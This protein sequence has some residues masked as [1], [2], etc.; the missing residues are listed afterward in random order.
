MSLL[1]TIDIQGIRSIGVGPQN[2]IVIEFLTPLTII[3]G[4]NGSGK[5]VRSYVSLLCS[6]AYLHNRFVVARRV[7]PCVYVCLLV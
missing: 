2:A 5:T 4:P 6:F 1:D 7:C 3:C